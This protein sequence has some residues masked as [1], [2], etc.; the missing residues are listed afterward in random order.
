MLQPHYH[1]PVTYLAEIS[2]RLF[3][4]CLCK[5]IDCL[6]QQYDAFALVALD[7]ICN[8]SSSI[9]ISMRSLN[10]GAHPCFSG[11]LVIK[12]ELNNFQLLQ[13]VS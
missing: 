6:A 1:I 5:V 11:F 4:H 8:P 10:S 9:M 13:T 12:Q 7:G 3:T 2:I